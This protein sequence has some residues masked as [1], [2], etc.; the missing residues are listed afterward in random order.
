MR[1]KL[2]LILLLAAV[3]PGLAQTGVKGILVDSQ[4][5]RPIPN[6]NILLTDQ[7]I[8]VMSGSD[9]SFQIT[10]AQVGKDVLHVIA[11]GYDDLYYDVDIIQ[12]LV[13]DLGKLS[14]EVS[15]YET[16]YL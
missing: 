12:N 11:Y 4:N 9:G 13:R 6:A 14:M 2:T 10:N 1:L 3:L 15:G 8:F 5:G 7:Q 16:S